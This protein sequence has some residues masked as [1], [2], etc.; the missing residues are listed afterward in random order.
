M[1]SALRPAYWNLCRKELEDRARRAVAALEDCRAC[2]RDCRVNRLEDRWAACKTGRYA[3]V[4][5]A[6][7]HFAKRSRSRR[8]SDSDA[9]TN[10][11]RII[12]GSLRDLL[13][14]N[15]EDH[16]GITSKDTKNTKEPY[17][18]TIVD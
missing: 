15:H 4:G 8:S 14:S 18:L 5:N 13:C 10:G 16:E 12:R 2:P 6:F 11:I 17:E 3:V 7:A 1:S 9:S